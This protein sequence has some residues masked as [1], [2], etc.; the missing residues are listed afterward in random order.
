[1]ST[2]TQHIRIH[3][4]TLRPTRIDLILQVS[5]GCLVRVLRQSN[6]PEECVNE[7]GCCN[8][9]CDLVQSQH[10]NTI[11][12]SVLVEP[13]THPEGVTSVGWALET[14]RL[15]LPIKL[16]RPA[17]TTPALNTKAATLIR[18][19]RAADLFGVTV[20]GSPPAPKM[21]LVLSMLYDS[22]GRS[23]GFT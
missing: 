5:T 10:T 18:C 21:L 4:N 12:S 15:F 22:N 6:S 17:A 7:Q 2:L 20:C 23:V 19:Q 1:M 9:N 16:R 13:Q 3:T 11:G 8:N 14:T